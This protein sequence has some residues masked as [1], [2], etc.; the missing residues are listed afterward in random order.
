[1]TTPAPGPKRKGPYCGGKLH[2]RDGTCTQAAGWGTPHPGHGRCKLH[3]GSAPSGR[4]AGAQ[5]Q[6]R[7]ELAQLGVTPVD[8]PLTELAKVTG[9]VIAWKN[10]TAALVNK[11]TSVRYDGELTG[12]QLRSEV[13]LWERALDRCEKFLTAMARCDIDERLARVQL[14]QI[15]LVNEA[16]AK[17]LADMGFDPAKQKQAQQLVARHLR[18]V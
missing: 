13:L 1:M 2:G 5:K 17:A 3:G 8:D 10:A 11:L 16:L 6:A 18:A 12:E 7:A 9:E 15:E 14:R 4:I